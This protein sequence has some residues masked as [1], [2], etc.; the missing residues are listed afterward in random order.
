MRILKPAAWGEC[1]GAEGGKNCCFL[2]HHEAPHV[3]QVS[4]EVLTQCN[5]NLLDH[6]M[7]SVFFAI[8]AVESKVLHEFTTSYGGPK[9]SLMGPTGR[10]WACMG[11]L[12][13]GET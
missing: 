7:E 1:F 8:V 5:M 3:Q 12:H 2:R 11:N 10:D 13:S 6:I 4:G 9:N